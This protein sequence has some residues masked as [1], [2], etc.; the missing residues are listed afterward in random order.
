MTN[1]LTEHDWLQIEMAASGCISG[2]SD[3]W[4]HLRQAIEK[5]PG[6]ESTFEHRKPASWL[7][8]FCQEVLL[9]KKLTELDDVLLPQRKA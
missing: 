3:E 7:R 9:L 4:P 6:Y 2:T 8:G 5:L 1:D